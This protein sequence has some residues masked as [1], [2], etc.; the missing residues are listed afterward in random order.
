M[1]DSQMKIYAGLWQR[2]GATELVYADRLP[3]QG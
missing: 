2:V 3:V 1:K